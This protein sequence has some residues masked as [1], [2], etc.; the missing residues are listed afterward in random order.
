MPDGATKNGQVASSIAAPAAERH[1]KN[2]IYVSEVTDKRGFLT[3]IRASCPR[4]LSAQIK[5]E[6]LML[7]LRAAEGFKAAVRA[8]RSLDRSKGVSFHTF[9]LPEDRCVRLLVKNLGRHMPEDVV[10]EEL[11]TLGICVQVI[12]QLR[13]GRRDQEAAKVRPLTPLIIVP[14]AREP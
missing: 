11:E 10:R 2:P 3:W 6:K 7:V 12:L 13:S 14:V 5:G 1:N 9:S 8:L 4:G